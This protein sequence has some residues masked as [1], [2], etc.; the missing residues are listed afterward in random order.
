MSGVGWVIPPPPAE[1]GSGVQGGER[2]GDPTSGPGGGELVQHSSA[3]GPL[4]E[5]THTACF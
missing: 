2:E 3:T 5:E 4:D 1:L